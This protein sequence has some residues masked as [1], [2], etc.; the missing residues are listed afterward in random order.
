MG[1]FNGRITYDTI[2]EA[3]DKANKNFNPKGYNVDTKEPSRLALSSKLYYKFLAMNSTSISKTTRLSNGRYFLEVMK[4]NGDYSR[5]NGKTADSVKAHIEFARDILR[6]NNNNR[7]SIVGV[8]VDVYKCLSDIKWKEAFRLAIDYCRK[9]TEDE[10][11]CTAYKQLYSTL[12]VSIE[13]MLLR[14]VDIE[15]SLAYG[16]S[17]E[18]AIANVQYENTTYMNKVVIPCISIISLMQNT[19]NPANIVKQT[20]IGE[21]KRNKSQETY[22]PYISMKSEEGTAAFL[23]TM[24][25]AAPSIASTGIGALLAIGGGITA[26]VL[27][28]HDAPKPA[29]GI[30]LAISALGALWFAFT[31]IP[32][33]RTINYYFA[34]SKV[35]VE[36]EIMLYNEIISNNILALEDKYNNMKDGPEKD[37]LAHVIEKQKQMYEESK[38]KLDQERAATEA[39]DYAIETAMNDD[40]DEANQDV[41]SS[42]GDDD[43]S[44]EDDGFDLII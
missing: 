22:G 4:S 13:T 19:P 37:K 15:Y 17:D 18:E 34:I 40:E 27:K 32:T 10:T 28:K 5:R 2:K 42:H 25:K 29:V 8:F 33:I 36:K 21:D 24:K 30:A 12:V 7:W 11:I 3:Y 43:S 1:F 26:G 41:E 38:A 9:H 16:M 20:I 39:D 31:I 35:D 23:D 44:D 14:I 6:R